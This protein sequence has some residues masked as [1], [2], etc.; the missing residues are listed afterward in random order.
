MDQQTINKEQAELYAVRLICDAEDILDAIQRLQD[1]IDISK[2][3]KLWNRVSDIK[4]D[5]NKVLETLKERDIA[6]ST[7]THARILT[8][9]NNQAQ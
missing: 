6:F 3:M 2:E 1:R 7:S 8:R 5:M 9:Y 4:F